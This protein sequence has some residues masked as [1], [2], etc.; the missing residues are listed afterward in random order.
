MH[1]TTNESEVVGLHYE[2]LRST[3]VQFSLSVK[4]GLA[5]SLAD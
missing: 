2:T 5:L 1:Q 4:N 3:A